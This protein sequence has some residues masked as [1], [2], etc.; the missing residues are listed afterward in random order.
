MILLGCSSAEEQPFQ[1]VPVTGTVKFEDGSVPKGTFATIRFE[2]NEIPKRAGRTAN[3]SSGNIQEDG[4]F[5][6]TYYGQDGAIVG[7]H[8]VTIAILANYPPGPNDPP[9]IAD[10]YK[11]ASTTPLGAEVELDGDNIFHF[12]VEKP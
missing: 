7:K 9:V 1:V 5:Q 12:K 3:P 6:L 8:K 2:P 11:D 10:M 4:S